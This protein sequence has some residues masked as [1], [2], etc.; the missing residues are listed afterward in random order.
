MLVANAR[1]CKSNTSPPV[2]CISQLIVFG[3]KAIMEFACSIPSLLSNVA[4]IARR[5]LI[6]LGCPDHRD[7][8]RIALICTIVKRK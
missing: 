5:S 2:S 8:V 1:I 6:A 3:M 4:V 7:R